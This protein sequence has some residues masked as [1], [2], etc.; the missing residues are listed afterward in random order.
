MGLVSTEV[1]INIT[2]RNATYYE[3]SGYLIPKK[4]IN[5]GN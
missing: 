4:I 3:K 1:E 5:M 2:S